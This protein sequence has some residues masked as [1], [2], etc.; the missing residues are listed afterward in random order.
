MAARP[1]AFTENDVDLIYRGLA[2]RAGRNATNGKSRDNCGSKG[3][4]Q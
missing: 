4:K 1:L 2:Q 3:E